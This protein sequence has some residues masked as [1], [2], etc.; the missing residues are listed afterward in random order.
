MMVCS[1]GDRPIRYAVEQRST[2]IV[3]APTRSAVWFYRRSSPQLCCTT[4]CSTE[5]VSSPVA[6]GMGAGCPGAALESSPP[7]TGTP[8][9]S[10]SPPHG[11]RPPIAFQGNGPGDLAAGFRIQ[12][13]RNST[14]DPTTASPQLDW[15][16]HSGPTS[17]VGLR[18]TRHS[19][20]KPSRRECAEDVNVMI[21]T[22]EALVAPG[23]GILAAD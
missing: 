19:D 3:L 9:T 8:R 18:A 16:A 17:L 13:R 5:R 14:P 7:S 15:P 23:K 4:R 20:E 10:A 6:H 11:A 2:P 1:P 12:T 22:A 21:R